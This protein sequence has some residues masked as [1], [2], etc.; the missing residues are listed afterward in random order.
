MSARPR[1]V[2]IA[3]ELGANLGHVAPLLAVARG[4]RER[5]HQVVFAL[6]N[7]TNADLVAKSG[8]AFLPA[9]AAPRL[10]AQPVYQ[11]Y[12]EMLAGECFPSAKAA[13]VSTL[14][15]RS[16]FRAARADVLL[17]DHAPGA[18]LAAR[19][20]PLRT[21]ACGVPFSIPPAGRPLPRFSP[22]ESGT[23]EIESNLLAR[24]NSALAVLR[25]PA[26]DAVSELYRA[27]AVAIE[28][29]PELDYFGPRPR[30]YYVGPAL[31]DAGDAQP[32]WPKAAGP[33]LL[34]YLRPGGHLASLLEAFRH[35]EASMLAYVPGADAK[36]AH[37]VH[38]SDT[39]LKMSAVL[40][41]CDA[42]VCHG[43]SLSCAA[44]LAGKP[45][46]LFPAY[47]EQHL[48]A[49]KAVEA[50]VATV[51]SARTDAGMLAERIEA[52]RPSGMLARAAARLARRQ[53]PRLRPSVEALVSHVE[54]A[55]RPQHSIPVP[56]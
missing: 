47:V 14:A 13:L 22:Q 28:W 52:L 2:L 3:W 17:A 7:L 51:A 48:S 31:G 53:D 15:W 1:R 23:A 46:L 39:P 36:S 12:A 5:G 24:L 11:S 29:L 56:S 38:F 34:V 18:L 50:G 6:R 44:A 26:L 8:F 43:G 54:N 16:I 33:K 25:G 35:S 45:M 27:D 32:E 40:P 42:L 41:Q 49:R 21:V 4:L 55:L 37:A 20:T 30:E 19:G 9:P 10:R